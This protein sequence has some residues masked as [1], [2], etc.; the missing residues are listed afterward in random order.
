[1]YYN[2]NTIIYFNGEFVKATNAK[3]DLY[4]QSLHYGYAVFEGIKSYQTDNGIKIFKAKEHYDR[5]RH[6]AAVMKMPFDISTEALIQLSY[7]VLEKNNFSD[8]YLRPVVFCSPNMSLSKGREAFLTITAW[9]WT[10]GYLANKMRLMTSSFCR[11]N[12]DAFHIDAKVSGHYVNSILACQEAR[13]HGFDDA[14]LLDGNGFVAEGPGANVFY[15]KDGILFTPAKGNILPGITRAT[16]IEICN[17]L[18]FQVIEKLFTLG[19]MLQA[20]AAFYCGTAAEI[21]ALES[22]DDITFKKNWEES[23][24]YIIQQAYK[25][26]VLEQQFEMQRVA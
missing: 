24:G 12:P 7:A 1:M 16:V 5:L 19:E 13:D 10:N 11:P 15:E 18:N 22:L 17:E 25:C 4:S 8:A 9:E 14:L 21:V 23:L 20:D 2:N 6:S 26:R 3:M